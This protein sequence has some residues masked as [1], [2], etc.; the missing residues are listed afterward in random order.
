VPAAHAAAGLLEVD[1]LRSLINGA[2]RSGMS[3]RRT[4]GTGMR[5]GMGTGAG[6]GRGVGGRRSGGGGLGGSAG[7]S[8]LSSFMRRR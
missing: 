3:G 1:V 7:R 4:G 5:S 6:M 2:L 8:L